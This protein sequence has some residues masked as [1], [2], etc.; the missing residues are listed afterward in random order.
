MIAILA[1]AVADLC[2]PVP[3]PV[4]PADPQDAARYVQVG[5]AAR[6]T[7]DLRVAAVAYR[8]ALAGDP[9]NAA[10]RAALDAICRA[11]RASGDEATELLAAVTLFRSGRYDAAHAALSAIAARGGPAQDG[12]HFFL[13]VIAL[14]DH[15]GG[16][17]VHQLELARRDPMYA[18][19][20]AS[21]LPLAHRD[22]TFSVVALIEPEL[23]TNPTLLPDTPPAGTMIGSP[24][25]DDDLLLGAIVTARPTRW[26]F[27]RDSIA[28]RKQH[29]Q[30]ELDFLG[31]T[32]SVGVELA[33]DGDRI[34]LRYDFD[35]DLI[36]GQPYLYA[37]RATVQ[38]RREL[39]GVAPAV[40]YS[41]R[42]RD[43]QDVAQAAFTG[44]VQQGDAGAIVHVTPRV[45]L[46]ARGAITR[47]HTEDASF[48]N[49]AFGPALQLRARVANGVRVS[50]MAAGWYA[51]YDG[52][53]PDGSVRR[54]TRGEASGDLELD[55]GDHALVTAG[56]GITRNL[57]TIDDFRYW[58]L[59][60][61]CG[62]AL[63]FG[64]P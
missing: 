25:I 49:V 21:L 5:D 32:A 62:L 17:A 29:V 11:E 37:H 34:G 56:A 19:P 7:G 58:K 30:D 44:W 35:Y 18:E 50:A 38:A 15:E 45:E 47:E 2:G 10:A 43:F 59:V 4:A 13:G 51:I 9:A 22:G 23:D 54:D 52:A 64:G 1:A 55:V 46:D 41:L 8:A 6:S 12:A 27:V 42:R 20:A 48:S 63:A 61:R 33:H 31:E 14:A 36:D 60:V 40:S 53:E 39:G 3:A 26:L 24:E 16:E 28:F 57:S